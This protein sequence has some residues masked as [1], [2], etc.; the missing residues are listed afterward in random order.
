MSHRMTTPMFKRILQDINSMSKNNYLLNR[1]TQD[2]QRR[3][4]DLYLKPKSVKI[5]LTCTASDMHATLKALYDF[6]RCEKKK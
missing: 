5:G 1:W 6:L 3:F 2:G 4:N